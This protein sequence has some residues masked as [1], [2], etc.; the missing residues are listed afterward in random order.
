MEVW[1]RPIVPLPEWAEWAEREGEKR[2]D[3]T[4]RL[5]LISGRSLSTCHVPTQI[6]TVSGKCRCRRFDSRAMLG[7]NP[8]FPPCFDSWENEN[9]Y[10]P[11]PPT[12]GLVLPFG[13]GILLVPR[14]IIPV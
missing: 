13:S 12:R 1:S 2:L 9:S 10:I 4:T 3:L 14:N 8:R 11:I 7:S 5:V 6:P